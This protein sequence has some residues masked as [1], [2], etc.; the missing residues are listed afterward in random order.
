MFV[1]NQ[2]VKAKVLLNIIEADRS[3][4]HS[5]P[6]KCSFQPIKC[7]IVGIKYMC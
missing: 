4:R 5:I 2:G 6:L 7:L 3:L 1:R